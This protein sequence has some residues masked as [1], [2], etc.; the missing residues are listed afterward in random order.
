MSEPLE[1]R[2]ARLEESVC[3]LEQVALMDAARKQ[4]GRWIRLGILG[5]VAAFYAYYMS[6]V[7]DMLGG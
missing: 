3:E 5:A 6:N 2:L 1:D 4:S 7:T